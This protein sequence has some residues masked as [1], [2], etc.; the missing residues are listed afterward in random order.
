VEYLFTNP[1]ARAA[2]LGVPCPAMASVIRMIRAIQ[3]IRGL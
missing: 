3:R 1:L 2:A